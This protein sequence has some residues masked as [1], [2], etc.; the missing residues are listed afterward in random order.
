MEGTHDAGWRQDKDCIGDILRTLFRLRQPF[1]SGMHRLR[2]FQRSVVHE[3]QDA[4]SRS[5]IQQ[6]R[7]IRNVIQIGRKKEDHRQQRD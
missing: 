2:E 3:E 5:R 6:L 7:A 4:R 1:P